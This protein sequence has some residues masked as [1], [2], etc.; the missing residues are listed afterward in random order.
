MASSGADICL[1]A[2]S[3]SATQHGIPEAVMQAVATAESGKLQGETVRPWP[4][5]VEADG[6]R[7]WFSDRDSAQSYLGQLR[8]S[9]RDDF[10]VGCFQLSHLSHAA[11]FASSDEMI[12]P[13]RNA[14]FAARFL[15]ELHDR[16][17]SW[18]AASRLFRIANP[19]APPELAVSEPRAPAEGSVAPRMA[20]RSASAGL[21][22]LVP[23]ASPWR[24]VD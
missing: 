2:A 13:A 5:T 10:F 1:E 14:D 8:R 23:V 4:W 6:K 9:G 3:R 18:E 22:S 7:R 16:A 15:L 19:V 17:G 24:K 21:G 12:D 20:A 11:A